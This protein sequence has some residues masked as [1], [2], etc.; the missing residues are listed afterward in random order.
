MNAPLASTC[1]TLEPRTLFASS[2]WSPVIDNPLFPLFPGTTWTYK[3]TSESDGAGEKVVTT[4]TNQTKLIQGVRT[5]VVLDKNYIDGALAEKTYDF[6]AQDRAGNVWYFGEQ[7]YEY[8]DGKVVSTEGSFLAGVNGAKPGIIMLAHPRVGDEYK[9]EQAVGVAEDEA[10]VLAVGET[11]TTPFATFAN[12]LKTKDFTK[13]EPGANEEKFYAPGIGL[14]MSQG[15]DGEVVRLTSVELA[16]AAFGDTIDNPYFPLVRGTKYV[17]KGT[18][19]GEPQKDTV[20][21]TRDTRQIQGVSATVVLDKVYV[22]GELKEKTYDFYAQDLAGNVWYFG[23]DTF[24]YEDGK[25]VSTAGSFLAGVN[26]AK[27]GIIMPAQP[28]VGSHYFEERAAGVAEDQARVI[29]TAARAVTPFATFGRCLQTE[30]FTDLEP[31][32]LEHKLYAPGFGLVFAS[33]VSG[34]DDTVRL[35]SV[36]F[37]PDTGADD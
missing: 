3:G 21:V 22:N 36:T 8:D 20:E 35:V 33:D 7:T 19:D 17:Y 5:T 6:F 25:V 34:G 18:S 31:G 15:S 4:V 30:N 32:A 11:A 2:G 1:E 10:E 28:D 27:A 12:C 26:G 24:E 9:Q 29:A 14:V 16:P 13:L 37:A 23:E